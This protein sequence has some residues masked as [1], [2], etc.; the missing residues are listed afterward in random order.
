MSEALKPG[1]AGIRRILEQFSENP[2]RTW[3]PERTRRR[4]SSGGDIRR[5]WTRGAVGPLLAFGVVAAF[6]LL[7]AACAGGS[8]PDGEAAGSPGD[9]ADVGSGYRWVMV[10][11]QAGL[12]DKG[13]NDLAWAGIARAAGELGGTAHVI[14]STEQAQYVPNL[15]QAVDDGASL[16]VGVG[17][18]ITDALEEVAQAN[19]DSAFVL[20]DSVAD[21]ARGAEPGEPLPNVQSVLF[22]E[23]E[24]AYLAGV[25]A[26]M[27]TVTGR[28]GFVGGM[29]IPPVL[30]FLS[31]LRQ[32][33]ASVNSEAEVSA[34]WVGSFGD[35][36]S[37]RELSAAEF[38]AGAD[39]VVEGAG[40]SGLGVFEEVEDRGSGHWVVGTDTCKNLLA[41]DN[42]LTDATKDVAGAVFRAAQ[43]VVDD[44]FAGGAATLGLDGDFVGL[45]LDTFDGLPAE[46]RAAANTAASAIKSGE[47][48]V[49][50]GTGA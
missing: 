50:P 29:K 20:I 44:T 12:G 18:L 11:D 42:H 33:V 46:I 28:I 17:F 30:R 48:E 37:G 2:R 27:T 35:P 43:Q 40:L 1:L 38:D 16:T 49:D 34:A 8:G 4:S 36:T 22:A 7:V 24:A 6:V 41:P 26:G 32:G 3:S 23:H 45:C 9:G 14:E 5:W 31:G 39:I 19:P 10:T 21:D 25:V 47:I 13:F 15:Q